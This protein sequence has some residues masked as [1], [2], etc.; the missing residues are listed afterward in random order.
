MITAPK[1]GTRTTVATA[2]STATPNVYWSTPW[3]PVN[4]ANFQ[5]ALASPTSY[6]NYLQETVYLGNAIQSLSPY[7]WTA[8]T[9]TE[10]LVVM[11]Q[12]DEVGAFTVTT[13]PTS[14]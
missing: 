9:S 10:T 7:G 12:N 5:A 11:M 3:A 8:T 14:G 2:V 1:S 4:D 6:Q 13:T